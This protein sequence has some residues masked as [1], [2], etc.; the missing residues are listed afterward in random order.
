MSTP[1]ELIKQRLSIVDVVGSYVALQKAGKSY[2]AKSPFTNERTPSFYVSPD[3]GMYYCFS[4]GKG[5]DMFTFIEEMEGVDFKGALKILAERAGVELVAVDPRS[6]DDKEKLHALLEDATLFFRGEI[7]KF[8]AITEYLDTRGVK[9]ETIEKWRIGYAPEGWRNLKDHLIKKGYTEEFIYRSGLLKKPDQSTNKSAGNSYDVF[10]DRIMF[11]IADSSGRVVGYSG[12]TFSK[13]PAAPKYVNSPETELFLKSHVLFGYDKAK[14]GIRTYDF[15]LVVE[16]QFDLVL[17]HQAGYTNTVAL[18]GTALSLQHVEL[19]QRLSNN[20]VLALD[21]DTAGIASVKR[22]ATVMLKRGMDVKVARIIG[23]KDPADLV[24]EDPKLLKQSVGHATHVI[25]FLLAILKSDTKDERTY[26]L[27]V[28]EEV[29]PFIALMPNKI[30]QEHFEHIVATALGVTTDSIHHEMQRIEEDLAKEKETPAQGVSAGRQTAPRVPETPRRAEDMIAHLLGIM[31][32]QEQDGTPKIV[33]ESL[34]KNLELVLGSA[35]MQSLIDWPKE[36][37]NEAIF[38]AETVY[39]EVAPKDLGRIIAE[40][41]GELHRNA[42]RN[43]LSEARDKLKK[44]EGDHDEEAQKEALA[45]AN[46]INE[47]LKKSHTENP[48]SPDNFHTSHN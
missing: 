34:R 31:L 10:R 7:K 26:K 42:L 2:K 29:L 15:S 21:A 12:R 18:S 38:K 35:S 41:L 33:V 37:Q 24:R 43:Q 19:L 6:R 23:G 11:P 3:R 8:P 20:V 28:R 44:A 46:E 17:S 16:G 48:F 32:W 22:A 9:P 39:T 25:E 45:R 1:V 30:D 13:D 14:Q 4:S 47:T 40:M 36:R 5:G 27:R